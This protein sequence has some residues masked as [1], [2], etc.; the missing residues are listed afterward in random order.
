MNITITGAT[1]FIGRHIVPALIGRGD[2]VTILTR[3]PRAGLNPKYA[4]WDA[5]SPPPREALEA[6]AVIHLGGESVAQRWTAQAKARI[7]NSR[8][9]GTRALVDGLGAAARPPAVLIS[10]S[11]IGI[12]GSRG[13]EVLTER[14]QPGSGFLEDVCVA[15]ER[16]AAR[17]MELGIRIVNPRFGIVLGQGGALARMLPAFQAGLGGKLGSG[18]QWM[19]WIHM[20]DVVGLLLAALN[21]AD[22]WGP[23]NATGPNPVT[24]AE[25][26]KELARVLKRP[27]MVPVPIFALKLL[28]GEMAEVLVSSQRVMPGAAIR[29]G[30]E[31]RFPELG[32][33]LEA[34]FDR[35]DQ[36]RA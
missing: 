36:S 5:Q 6:D 12:Y 27:A 23:L 19:S 29:C 28:F 7:R 11:A 21:H 35:G 13:D 3:S 22:L 2:Q 17:A 14:S 1:G 34:L 31:F 32:P 16:E 8:I 30:Y 9:D 24:N 15:W 10:A 20:D 25:F 4:A 26:T 18:D 33:A